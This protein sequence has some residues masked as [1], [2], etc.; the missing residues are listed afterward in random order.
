MINLATS[1]ASA[2]NAQPIRSTQPAPLKPTAATRATRKRASASATAA[3]EKSVFRQINRYRQQQG[4]AALSTNSSIT[5]QARRHSQDM[6]NSGDISHDGFEGRVKTIGKTI[7]YR[8]AAENVAY[9]FGFESPGAQ[10]VTG[11]LNSPGHLD[12]IV[13]NFNLTGIGVAKNSRGEYYFTQIF[14]KR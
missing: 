1:S 14:I 13:G 8:S 5:R 4:L 3:L 2:L 9:N 12:N 11:W 10:A 6:A 7:R